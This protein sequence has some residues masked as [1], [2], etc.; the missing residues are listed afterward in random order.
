MARY[1]IDFAV[2]IR[3]EIHERDFSGTMALLFP[4]LTLKLCDEASVLEVPG[5]DK[6]VEKMVMEDI[7][8]MKDLAYLDLS[9]RPHI[10]T[11]VTLAHSEGLLVP[12][13]PINTQRGNVE[14]I[15]EFKIV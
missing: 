10:P 5:V 3:Q 9:G 15:M 7:K 8:M 1:N 2:I 12:I 11:I 6:R 4:C 13:E 14:V